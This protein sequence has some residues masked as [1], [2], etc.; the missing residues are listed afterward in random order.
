MKR[1]SIKVHIYCNS[2]EFFPKNKSPAQIRKVPTRMINTNKR[3][4]LPTVVSDLPA[5]VN[6]TEYTPKETIKLLEGYPENSKQKSHLINHLVA[7]NLVP[8]KRN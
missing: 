6:G 8:I 3:V 2:R 5:P 7:S 1:T 4:K